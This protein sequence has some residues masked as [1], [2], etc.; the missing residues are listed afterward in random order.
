[1]P[2]LYY[3]SGPMPPLNKS[4]FEISKGLIYGVLLIMPHRWSAKNITYY[5][6]LIIL[7]FASIWLIY[8]CI[9]GIFEYVAGRKHWAI[10]PTCIA[11]LILAASAP[12]SLIMRKN[13]S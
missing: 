5:F 8:I 1:M 13:F 10:I 9:E 7:S 11:F 6:K 4:I 3:D 2:E 12:L